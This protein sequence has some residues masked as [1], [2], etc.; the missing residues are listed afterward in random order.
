METTET[1]PPGRGGQGAQ[2]HKVK[3]CPRV[4]CRWEEEWGSHG[5]GN[6]ALG[7][8]TCLSKILRVQEPPET[9]AIRAAMTSNLR[10]LHRMQWLEQFEWRALDWRA[11]GFMLLLL[12]FTTGGLGRGRL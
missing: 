2:P 8:M 7:W 1:R 11:M 12:Y 4:S 3:D 10:V 9:E 5:P 6:A